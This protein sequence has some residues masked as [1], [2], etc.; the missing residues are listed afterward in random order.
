M[1]SR[2][3]PRSAVLCLSLAVAPQPHAQAQAPAPQPPPAQPP[4]TEPAPPPKPNVTLILDRGPQ[5]AQIRLAFPAFRTAAPLGGDATRALQ[6][7]ESTVRQDLAYSGYF[8][9]QG[10]AE[11]AG[12]PLTGDVQRDLEVYRSRNNQVLLTGDVKSEED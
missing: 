6:E 8:E 3:L 1:R 11:L 7:L 2:V 12:A 10:P 4:G 9:I 5:R